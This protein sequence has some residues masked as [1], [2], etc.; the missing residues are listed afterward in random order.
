MRGQWRARGVLGIGDHRH[1]KRTTIVARKYTLLELPERVDD[2][3]M[4]RYGSWTCAR[5]ARK[6]KG[7]PLF[8]PQLKEAITQRL[9]RGE[10]TILF[11]N[12]AVTQL[13]CNARSAVMSAAVQIAVLAH[14]PCM[15]QKLFVSHL[16]PQRKVP[17]FAR[18]KL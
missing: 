2:Q 5:R 7:T 16:R 15:E 10:Q 6:E 14:L 11:L 3:K 18:T 8:S 1:W 17:T 4:P 12:G 13:H 9:E